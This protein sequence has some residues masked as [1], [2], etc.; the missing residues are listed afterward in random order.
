MWSKGLGER[1]QFFLKLRSWQLFCLLV[2]LPFFGQFFVDPFSLAARGAD[3]KELFLVTGLVVFLSTIIV[4]VW[5][6][7]LGTQLNQLVAQELRPS[8]GLFKVSVIFPAV[9]AL[10][11]VFLF[12]SLTD[13]PS[14]SWIPL[15]LCPFH[16]LAMI[17]SLY[18]PYFLSKNLVLAERRGE[19]KTEDFIGPFF[20]FCLFPVGIW[21]I[22]PRVNAL[23]KQ[24]TN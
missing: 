22:Q 1:M 9:Y 4:L 14:L 21:F 23:Y 17:S 16:L 15:F 19:I 5:F 7:A 10:L 8:S 20:A 6:W 2:A 18:S 11:F 13:N 24:H 3:F 12:F